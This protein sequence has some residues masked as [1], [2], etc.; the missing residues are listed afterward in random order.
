MPQLLRAIALFRVGTASVFKDI[1]LFTEFFQNDAF[2]Y[3]LLAYTVKISK[4]KC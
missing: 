3:T 1:H 2:S 4:H